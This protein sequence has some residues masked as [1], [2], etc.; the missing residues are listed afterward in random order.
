MAGKFAWL[1][2]N[3]EKTEGSFVWSDGR[4]LGSFMKW[5]ADYSQFKEKVD[6]VKIEKTTG[7]WHNVLGN[8]SIDNICT[9][10]SKLNFDIVGCK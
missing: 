6:Y 5:T 3:D 10:H 9:K 7:S 2:L 1:G 4:P 8:E